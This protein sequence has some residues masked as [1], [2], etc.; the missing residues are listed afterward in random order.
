MA[1]LKGDILSGVTGKI[2][3]LIFYQSNGR[4]LVRT[5]PSGYRD[6]KSLSQLIQRQRFSVTQQ[7]LKSFR[8]VIN[9]YFRPITPNKTAFGEAL[10]WHL[11]NALTGEYPNLRIDYTQ[12][13]LT[14]GELPLPISIRAIR[15]DKLLIV[16]W[17]KVPGQFFA[18]SLEIVYLFQP[19]E[20]AFQSGLIAQRNQQRA[21][22]ELGTSES[23][24]Y[25]WAYFVSPSSSKVSNSVYLGYI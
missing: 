12:T 4:T 20:R 13:L 17:D 18:D 7:F 15:N 23:G 10:A 5:R 6:Q 14:R 1:R 19:G 2:S 3:N 24:V 21:V 11:K 16:E 8:P 9:N 25:L 22:F